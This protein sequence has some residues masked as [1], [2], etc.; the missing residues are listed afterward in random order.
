VVGL[1][2]HSQ[3]HEG[4]HASPSAL[5]RTTWI[6]SSRKPTSLA[7]Q[8]AQTLINGALRRFIEGQAPKLEDTLRR[9]VR[10]VIK[11]GR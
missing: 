11:A 5:I 1:R 8:S 3:S 2:P 4:K 9:I 10:E 7:A 6:T